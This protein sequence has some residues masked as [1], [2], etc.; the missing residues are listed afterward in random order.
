M[1]TVHGS[2]LQLVEAVT[3]WFTVGAVPK[4]LVVAHGRVTAVTSST[5]RAPIC[6]ILSPNAL[7]QRSHQDIRLCLDHSLAGPSCPPGTARPSLGRIMVHA[8]PGRVYGALERDQ[9]PP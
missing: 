4:G 8:P 7:V 3:R 2:H 5:A 6:L 9:P 1:N